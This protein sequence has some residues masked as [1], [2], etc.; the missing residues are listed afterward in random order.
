MNVENS[1]DIDTRPSGA[2][3]AAPWD[4]RVDKDRRLKPTNPLSKS[5]LFGSRRA[6]RRQADETVQLYVDRYG[7]SS[8]LVLL[9]ALLLSVADGFLTLKI[10]DLG[11]S[12]LNP[13]MALLLE[14]GPLTFILGKYTL[15]AVCLLSLLVHENYRLFGER[16]VVRQL[17]CAVPLIY[18]TLLCYEIW[19]LYLGWNLLWFAK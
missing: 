18:A 2:E 14:R 3:E 4:R 7:P 6:Y 10:L 15:T 12:E 19:L 17:F 1:L 16:I 8:V 11:G 5:S 9:S 13:I